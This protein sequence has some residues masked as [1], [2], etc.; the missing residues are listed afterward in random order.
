M[1][2]LVAG[3]AVRQ[4]VWTGQSWS[5]S[6][7]KCLIAQPPWRKSSRPTHLTNDRIAGVR[8]WITA[9]L[10]YFPKNIFEISP[11]KEDVVTSIGASTTPRTKHSL[12]TTR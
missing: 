9:V 6:S 11:M 8:N 4:T 2:V 12:R 7:G 1:M 3:L 5:C 10:P